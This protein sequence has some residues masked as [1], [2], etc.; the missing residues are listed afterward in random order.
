MARLEPI[1][2]ILQSHYGRQAPGWPTDPYLFL[3]W[4]QCGYPPS[5]ERCNRGW[6]ALTAAVA[7]APAELAAARPATLARAL[8][9][10]GIV[11]ELRAARVRQIARTVKEDF[12]GDLR[13]V[14][15]SAPEAEAGRLLKR[16]PGVSDPGADRI[17]LFGALAAVPAV[18]SNSPYVPLRIESGRV[19]AKYTAAYREARQLIA[20]QLPATLAARGRAYLLLRQHARQLCKA[21]NPRCG[22]CPVSGDCAYFAG[23]ARKKRRGT[24]RQGRALGARRRS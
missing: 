9:A 22:E 5:E 8:K 11:P 16:F 6:E 21:R 15:A 18:P 10:G 12:G 17:L 1:L 24:G 23:L 19:P 4:W 2:N 20:A 3:I 7:V 14:L 13:A